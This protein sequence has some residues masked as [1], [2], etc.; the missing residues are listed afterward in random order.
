MNA[1]KERSHS[2]LP[3]VELT[4][5]ENANVEMTAI[6]S[7]C[8]SLVR[9]EPAAGTASLASLALPWYMVENLRC[10]AA[11]STPARKH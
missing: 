4:R 9:R 1:S 3:V 10:R 8:G 7:G 11:A 2:D 6:I 5:S